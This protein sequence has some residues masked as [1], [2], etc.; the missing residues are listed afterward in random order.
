MIKKTILFIFLLL[1]VSLLFYQSALASASGVNLVAFGADKSAVET[2]L[3]KPIQ[4]SLRDGFEVW[5]YTSV[6]PI[7]ADFIYFKNNQ[8]VMKSV[9][10]QGQGHILSQYISK[11]G[12][13]VR[14]M[15]KYQQGEEDPLQMSMHIWNTAGV[16]VQSSGYESKSSVI[17]TFEFA[18]VSLEAY[19][20]NLAPDLV[21]NKS[22]NVI[23]SATPLISPSQTWMQRAQEMYVT[24]T[25]YLVVG[26]LGFVLLF[27]LLFHR[28]SS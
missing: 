26:V 19:F 3:G 16:A 22:L 18:P 1:I 21:G 25:P 14:S 4:I 23:P 5:W 28:G 20:Q 9:S 6:D 10:V 8:V 11:Y 12:S 15:F 24:K 2:Q 27:L 17:R 13:P 7:S